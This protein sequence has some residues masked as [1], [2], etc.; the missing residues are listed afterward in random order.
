MSLTRRKKENGGTKDWVVSFCRNGEKYIKRFPAKEYE[1][2]VE[3]HTEMKAKLPP[4]I[5]H[6]KG[7]GKTGRPKVNLSS[8]ETMTGCTLEKEKEGVR[9]PR[10]CN[11]YNDCLTLAA[12]RSWPGFTIKQEAL[13]KC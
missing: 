9:C 4:I 8:I 7:G 13:K 12:I 1:K 6:S 2:A 3:H 11:Y 5:R 10:P